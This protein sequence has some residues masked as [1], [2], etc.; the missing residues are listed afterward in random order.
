[1]SKNVEDFGGARESDD[2]IYGQSLRSRSEIT[3]AWNILQ[4][5]YWE[6]QIN[7]IF[8]NSSLIWEDM[9]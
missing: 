6:F 3:K 4:L 2:R 7:G 9:L 8:N 1:M 5:C